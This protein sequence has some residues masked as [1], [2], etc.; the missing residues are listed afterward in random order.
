MPTAQ[1]VETTPHAGTY[2]ID[3][4][5]S[6]I[7]FT[8]K[9][10]FGTG[11]V[12]GT[13]SDVSGTIVI[14]DPASKSAV[15]ASAAAGSFKTSDGR[16]DDKVRSAKFLHADKHPRIMFESTGVAE[17]GGIWRLEGGLT[18]A[19]GTA[20]VHLTITKLVAEPSGLV[21]SAEGTVDRYAHGITAMKGM[22]ARRLKVTITARASRA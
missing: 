11:K 20:P 16:R 1:S 6:E 10:L 4:Q 15:A 12:E 7:R 17:E 8:T 21:I 2:I 3:P 13:F 14:A 9:H 22:A 19:G 5:E 18:A